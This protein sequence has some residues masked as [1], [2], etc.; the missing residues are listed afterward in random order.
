MCIRD[1][2]IFVHKTSPETWYIKSLD[3]ESNRI[4]MI[5]QT[6]TGSEDFELLSD[7]TYI[8]GKGSTLYF[9]NPSRNDTW[10]EIV[11]L[12]EY[13]IMNINRLATSRN[14]LILVNNP[15]SN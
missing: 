14:R 11:D 8:M 13:G 5:T 2:L 15:K 6:V 1:S 12:T 7:G 4:T 3:P 9:I 10:T